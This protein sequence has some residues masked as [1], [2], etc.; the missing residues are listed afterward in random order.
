MFCL[1]YLGELCID[2]II[3]KDFRK[4]IR[5]EPWKSEKSLRKISE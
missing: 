3:R 2:L 4:K 1:V 5:W